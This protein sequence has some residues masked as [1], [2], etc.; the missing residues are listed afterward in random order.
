VTFAETV[1]VG[2]ISGLVPGTLGIAGIFVT[3]GRAA[4]A[5][6]RESARRDAEGEEADKRREAASEAADIR[7]E[8]AQQAADRRRDIAD[9]VRWS[10]D[11]RLAVYAEFIA[12]ADAW[13][14]GASDHAISRRA[15]GQTADADAG[16]EILKLMRIAGRSRGLLRI[17]AT[18]S[19]ENAAMHVTDV[20]V[21][22]TNLACQAGLPEQSIFDHSVA[23]YVI[24]FNTLREAIRE[25]LNIVPPSAI[26]G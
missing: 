16:T 3:S 19:V 10:T 12:D 4:K 17:L 2:V 6:E 15:S 7:R 20:C 11:K 24:A 22:L 1:L 14:Q 18:E 21:A 23:E 25:E 9:H 26:T 13:E 5:A 8:A